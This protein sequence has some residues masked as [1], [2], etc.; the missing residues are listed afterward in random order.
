M[1]LEVR[2][3]FLR[4]QQQ[5]AKKKISSGEGYSQ[6]VEQLTSMRQDLKPWCPNKQVSHLEN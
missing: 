2:G 6:A 4:E 1:D 3:S 5:D